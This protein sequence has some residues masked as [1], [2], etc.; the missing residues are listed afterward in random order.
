M[1]TSIE[2]IFTATVTYKNEDESTL[3]ADDIQLLDLISI[4]TKKV[5]EATNGSE[6]DIDAHSVVVVT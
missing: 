3:A 5:E 1:A 2:K 4:M 6:G